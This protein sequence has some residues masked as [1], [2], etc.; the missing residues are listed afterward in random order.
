MTALNAKR[1]SKMNTADMHAGNVMYSTVGLRPLY[2][3]FEK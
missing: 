2:S 1:Y 3:F